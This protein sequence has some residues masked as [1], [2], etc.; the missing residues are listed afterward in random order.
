MAWPTAIDVA[1]K[2]WASVISALETGRQILLLRKGGILEQSGK[3]RFAI[4]HN[5]F[6]LFPT[7]LHQSRGELKAEVEL[8]PVSAE[9]KEI[10][11]SSAGVISEILKVDSRGQLDRL[12]DLH[13]WTRSLVDLRFNYKPQNPLYLVLVRVYRL[14]E[15]VLLENTPAY[16]GCKSWVPLAQPIETG[17]A[18]AVLD[19]VKFE[20]SRKMVLERLA[21]SSPDPSP[22]TGSVDSSGL[23]KCSPPVDGHLDGR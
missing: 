2:E 21:Q 19:D 12:D 5:E 22:G 23:E 18:T 11:I 14:H 9:P 20:H 13:I 8:E 17:N 7:Y 3:N 6:V 10:R 16:A 15:P 4:A 1:L